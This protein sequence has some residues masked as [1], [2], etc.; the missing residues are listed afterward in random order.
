VQGRFS[1]AVRIL[2]EGAAKD[3]TSR[4]V[5]SAAAKLVAAAYA[6]LSNGR[7]RP[8]VD[9]A[10]SALKNSSAAK[11]R[12]LAARVFIDTGEMS[13]AR[14]LVGLSGL[15]QESRAYSKSSKAILRFRWRARRASSV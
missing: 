9:T 11:I 8:A 4:N 6:E 3:L 13:R 12:F 7:K 1:E 5:D 15:R 2:Q 14:E 10:L